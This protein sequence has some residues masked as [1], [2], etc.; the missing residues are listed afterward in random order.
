[1]QERPRSGSAEE[2]TRGAISAKCLPRVPGISRHRW[3]GPAWVGVVA[4][5]LLEKQYRGWRKPARLSR[6]PDSSARPQTCFPPLGVIPEIDA[7]E[8]PHKKRTEESTIRRGREPM[9]TGEILLNV[10]VNGYHVAST[11]ACQS[12]LMPVRFASAMV[13]LS[14]SPER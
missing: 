4:G 5:G 7:L 3:R 9:F 13:R 10:R 8:A 1:V 14:A 6:S 12:R 2:N 11:A